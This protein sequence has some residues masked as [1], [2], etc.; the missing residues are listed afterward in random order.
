MQLSLLQQLMRIYED[1]SLNLKKRV[2]VNFIGEQGAD[3]GV[4][5]EEFFHSAI[6]CLSKVDPA[7]NV[8]LFWGSAWPPYTTL[9]C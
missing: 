4:P 5:T 9:W 3:M 1:R 7:F 8:Q 2:D 6:S